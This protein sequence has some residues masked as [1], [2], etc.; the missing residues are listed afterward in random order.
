M[1]KYEKPY[2]VTLS[3]KGNDNLCGSCSANIS[4][5]DNPFMYDLIYKQIDTNHN[6]NIEES[7]R[8][9]CFGDGECANI[10]TSY[11]KFGSTAQTLA[12]S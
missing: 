11:C 10:I 1:K 9:V 2:L 3:V 6:N 7:E 5:I 12:W 8:N 4:D